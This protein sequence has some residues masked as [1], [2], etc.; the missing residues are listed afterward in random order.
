MIMTTVTYYVLPATNNK[1][2][3]VKVT[4]MVGSIEAPYNFACGLHTQANTLIK[5]LLKKVDWDD[6][7][8]HG[9]G[10]LP[11]GQYVVL[12]RRSKS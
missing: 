2:T 6:L 1:G 3:R 10:Q 11:N 9:R 8:V 4:C 7:T 12:L 5:Q